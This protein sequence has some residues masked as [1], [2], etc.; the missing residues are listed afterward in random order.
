MIKRS[1][2]GFYVYISR[3][4]RWVDR[5]TVDTF[6]RIDMITFPHVLSAVG[7]PFAKTAQNDFLQKTCP[8]TCSYTLPVSRE[9]YRA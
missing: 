9:M 1:E 4:L 3:Q 7:P 5:E 8:A 6:H 2:I